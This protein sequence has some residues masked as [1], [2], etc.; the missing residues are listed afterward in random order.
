MATGEV[1]PNPS[2]QWVRD[3]LVED[4]KKQLS[5]LGVDASST[6]VEEQ[7]KRDLVIT[8]N[9]N[10]R[11]KPRATPP[12]PPPPAGNPAKGMAQE[13]G[14]EFYQAPIDKCPNAKQMQCPVCKGHGTMFNCKFCALQVRMA[15][16]TARGDQKSKNVGGDRLQHIDYIYPKFALEILWLHVHHQLGSGAFRDIPREHSHGM[17]LRKMED[18]CDRSNSIPGLPN[19]WIK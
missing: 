19:W 8:D 7:V 13:S 6:A 5:E 14:A 3:T 18:I 1:N 2:D 12:L 15:L 11:V 9:L 16:L 17:L 10:E 4:R